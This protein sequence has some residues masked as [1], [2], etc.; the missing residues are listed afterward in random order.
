ML[1]LG[2]ETQVYAFVFLF[3]KTNRQNSAP[4]DPISVF[5]ADSKFLIQGLSIALSVVENGFIQAEL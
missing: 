3:K 4:P 5:S 2:C 1:V